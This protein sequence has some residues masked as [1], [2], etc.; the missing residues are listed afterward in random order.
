MKVGITLSNYGPAANPSAV[1]A[2]ASRAEE[3][4]F[5]TLWVADRLLFPVEP[6][7]AY[8]VTPDGKLP[9]VFRHSLEPLTVLT[10][11]AAHTRRIGLGTGILQM[12]FYNA[13]L[14]WRQ[15]TT[16]DIFSQGRLVVGLGQGWSEDEFE[17]VGVS[18]KERASR[19]DE[20]LDCLKAL[21]TQQ[22]AS[23]QGQ[24]FRVAP[25]YLAQPH[26]KPNPRL[27]L[28]AFTPGALSRVARQADGWLPV[29]IPLAGVKA[30]W[31]QILQQAQ[32]L[33]RDPQSLELRVG[34]ALSGDPSQT[35][36]E[37][38]GFS[39]L[40]AREFYFMVTTTSQDASDGLAQL[41]KIRQLADAYF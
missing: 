16:L 13:A 36:E 26:Q 30:M 18:P 24:H 31:S 2:F 7:S 6:R 28:A 10:W 14:L 23:Y 29:G 38:A 22:P 34:G 35:L 5:E 15:L 40:G 8:A 3:L 4:G 12:P 19:A 9:D 37:L 32:A 17:A 25:S 21:W 27:L 20:L 11:A 33:G 39:E 1:A 41:D